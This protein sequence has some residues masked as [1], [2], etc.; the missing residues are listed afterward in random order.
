MNED[1]RE[2]VEK[3]RTLGAVLVLVI[4]IFFIFFTF[5]SQREKKDVSFKLKLFYSDM[6]QTMQYS[7]NNNG[8]VGEWGWSSNDKASF[9]NDHIINYLHVSKKC[10]EGESDCFESDSYLNLR[11]LK[12]S[13]DFSIYPS[14]VLQNGVSV[15]FKLNNGC[16]KNGSVCAFVFVDIN[17]NKKPNKFGKDLF[18]FTI[19]NSNNTTFLPFK[20]SNDVLVFLNDKKYGCSKKADV[21]MYCAAYLSTNNW[22][23]D[24]S[25]PW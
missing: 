6:M 15:A 12:T 21:P 8:P 18:V 20:N 14:I 10:L 25:Y 5:L 24:S 1:L 2:F 16:S 9:L 4:V 3:Y 22:S 7:I 13:Y 23:I 19:V 17:G 11:N